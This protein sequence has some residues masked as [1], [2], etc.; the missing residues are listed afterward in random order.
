ML[1]IEGMDKLRQGPFLAAALQLAN[2]HRRA[3]QQRD[4]LAFDVFGRRQAG[5][6]VANKAFLLLNS[7][8]HTCVLIGF[9]K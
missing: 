2:P 3:P 4:E 9:F 8:D 6:V 5:T 1:C 7:N